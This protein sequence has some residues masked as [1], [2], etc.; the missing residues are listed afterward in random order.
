M[1]VHILS[2]EVVFGAFKDDECVLSIVIY[3]TC[4]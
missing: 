2:R 1:Y 4:L 3:L